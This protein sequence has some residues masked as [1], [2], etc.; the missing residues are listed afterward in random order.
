MADWC[1]C[2]RL[3][4]LELYKEQS[5]K[6]LNSFGGYITLS[7]RPPITFKFKRIKQRVFFEH[8]L[9]SSYLTKS[10]NIIE[11]QTYHRIKKIKRNGKRIQDNRVSQSQMDRT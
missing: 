5:L 2:Q 9:S 7:W 11:N 6:C 3:L 10:T 8:L 4:R 1:N